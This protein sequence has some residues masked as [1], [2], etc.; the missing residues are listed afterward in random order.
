[1]PGI[2]HQFLESPWLLNR[3]MV[4]QFIYQ[5]V[6]MYVCMYTVQRLP[7]SLV[8]IKF[9]EMALINLVQAGGLALLASCYT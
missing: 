2:D 7:Y 3:L 6:C 5:Y 1:M 4:L 8:S 9:G